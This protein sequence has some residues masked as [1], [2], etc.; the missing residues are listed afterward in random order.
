[1]DRQRRGGQYFDCFDPTYHVIDLRE[2]PDAYYMAGQWNPRWAG[3]DWGMQHAIAVYL[4]TKALVK[5]SV[6]DDYRLEDSVLR[7]V[8]CYRR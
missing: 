1:M 7:G 6:G 5:N 8:S 3:Q 4:F 2:D